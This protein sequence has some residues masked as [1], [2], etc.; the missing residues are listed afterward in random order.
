M[1]SR[2]NKAKVEAE[3]AIPA[4]TSSGIAKGRR[5][6]PKSAPSIIAN[7]VVMRG[8]L[9]SEG[10]VQ[11]DGTFDGSVR[12]STISIGESANVTGLMIADEISVH[13]TLTGQ[14]HARRVQLHAPCCFEGDITHTELSI[15]LGAKFE[16][17]LRRTE[18]PLIDRT[19]MTEDISPARRDRPSMPEYPL[20]TQPQLMPLDAHTGDEGGA[21]KAAE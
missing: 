3:V 18:D 16:G 2:K 7:D 14:I 4:S 13:G 6:G 5:S 11:I 19:E 21:I 20:I 10:M 17:H 12:A 8:D 15:E 9:V 1:F